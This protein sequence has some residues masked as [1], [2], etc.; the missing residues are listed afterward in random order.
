[1]HRR[2]VERGAHLAGEERKA[3]RD[4]LVVLRV[5]DPHALVLV[6]PR[7]VEAGEEI[8]AREHEDAA[9]LEPPIELRARDRQPGQPQPHE[10]RAFELVYAERDAFELALEDL[11]RAAGLVAVERHDRA[12]AER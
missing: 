11:S 7:L 2:A 8:V 12:P 4:R 9:F 6:R 3:S 10:E 5:R 1:M